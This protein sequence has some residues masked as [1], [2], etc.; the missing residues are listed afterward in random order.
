MEDG[1]F[2]VLP[3]AVELPIVRRNEVNLICSNIA[4]ALS[5][6]TLGTEDTFHSNARHRRYI[7]DV[8]CWDGAPHL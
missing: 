6:Q 5:T 8:S 4:L 2:K 7:C 1:D 3:R